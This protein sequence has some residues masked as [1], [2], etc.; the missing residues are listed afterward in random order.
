[1]W[2]VDKSSPE[3]LIW[4]GHS[5]RG[6]R[7]SV[8]NAL[9][10]EKRARHRY[11]IQDA[12]DQAG[13]TIKVN[14]ELKQLE[15]KLLEHEVV[16]AVLPATHSD[17]R[18]LLVATNSRIMFVFLGWVNRTELVYDYRSISHM[19][20]LGGFIMG[21]MRAYVFGTQSSIKFTQVWN[22]VGKKF[23]HIV[24][25]RTES[26]SNVTRSEFEYNKMARSTKATEYQ[27]RP[28]D[29][30]ANE[31]VELD[32]QFELGLIEKDV[33]LSSKLDLLKRMT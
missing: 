26:I 5:H 31:V 15:S 13:I 23:V 22:P 30:L 8:K 25:S 19:R 4:D 24:N 16:L 11:D 14:R 3:E 33:Y 32:S 18:G 7:T 10:E 9:R 20:W 28:N 27:V 12:V 1:M 17:E 29:L 21:R 6:E 2:V